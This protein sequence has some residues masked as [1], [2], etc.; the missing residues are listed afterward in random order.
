MITE[1]REITGGRV[2]C[3]AFGGRML[4]LPEDGGAFRL[5][6]AFLVRPQEANRA[7]TV[8]WDIPYALQNALALK[9]SPDR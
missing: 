2:L 3:A 1:V 4:F 7:R 6:A 9:L 8:S 5:T